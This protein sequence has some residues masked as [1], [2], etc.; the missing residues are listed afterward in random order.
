MKPKF[1]IGQTIYHRDY[2]DRIREIK[3]QGVIKQGKEFMY[4][5]NEGHDEY[6]PYSEYSEVSLFATREE[7]RNNA[8]EN[9][10]KR[11]NKID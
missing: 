9:Y 11:L 5:L 6:E 3:I 4:I 1:E 2:K 7:C 8:I 10:R